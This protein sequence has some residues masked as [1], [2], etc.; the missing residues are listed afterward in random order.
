MSCCLMCSSRV[1]HIEIR[2]EY[3]LDV[4][5]I[6]GANEHEYVCPVMRVIVAVLLGV[7]AGSDVGEI[8]KLR[9]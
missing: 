2:P 1:H 4:G 5:D 8:T 9:L 6:I 3:R 7:I